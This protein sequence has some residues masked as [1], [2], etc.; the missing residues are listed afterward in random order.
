MYASSVTISNR[1][2][3]SSSWTGVDEWDKKLNALDT[4][5]CTYLNQFDV[6]KLLVVFI[7]SWKLQLYNLGSKFVNFKARLKRGSDEWPRLFFRSVVVEIFWEEQSR[8]FRWHPCCPLTHPTFPVFTSIVHGLNRKMWSGLWHLMNCEDGR[9]EWSS[10]IFF[11]Q[12]KHYEEGK[13]RK[14]KRRRFM[15]M[16]T[17][18]AHWSVAKRELKTF[19][20]PK[21]N[22]KSRH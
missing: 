17:R 8:L 14:R 15:V 5:N 6:K 13:E 7:K 11:R 16:G 21:E 12:F 3:S 10:N 18:E 19:S 4:C 22:K 9:I 20:K 2:S 1:G